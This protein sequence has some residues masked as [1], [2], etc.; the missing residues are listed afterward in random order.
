MASS[1]L[2][3]IPPE[4]LATI[5]AALA[6][7]RPLRPPRDLCALRATC[8]HLRDALSCHYNPAVWSA[9]FD[10]R[11][12]SAAVRRRNFSPNGRDYYDQLRQYAE[13]LDALRSGTVL[14]PDIGDIL[15]IVYVMLLD[16]DGKNRAQLEAAGVDAFLD[17]SIRTHLWSEAHLHEGWPQDDSTNSFALWI[18]WM[19]TTTEQLQRETAAV[20]EEMVALVMPF[21][22]NAYRYA[23]AEAPPHHFHLPLA[24]PA[25][26][27]PHSFPSAHGPYPVYAPDRQVSYPYFGSLPSFS[28]PPISVAAKLLYFARRE[29]IPFGIPPHIPATRAVAPPSNHPSPTQ[30]DLHEVNAHKGAEPPIRITW[31]W[32]SGTRL[33]NGLP[34]SQL[35]SDRS[36][37]WDSDYWR[38]RLCGSA[39]KRQ[40][41][42][43]PAKLYVPGS[44]DGLWQG[45]LIVSLLSPLFLFIFL[46]R[47]SSSRHKKPCRH[48]FE[49]LS[50]PRK[51]STK[52][53]FESR[54]NPYS[55]ALLN[56]IPYSPTI[57]CHSLPS[58]L[59]S[60]KKTTIRVGGRISL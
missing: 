13:V 56:T 27:L 12:D 33:A 20:R 4:I 40:P 41:K 29:I 10:S 26:D 9:A 2:H 16:N 44:M 11:F 28:P 52:C 46:H 8:R 14:R 34:D 37:R 1:P 6:S 60:R 36:S 25:S 50:I 38:R 18:K 47:C 51:L 43:R 17:A 35:S 5:A 24:D 3:R 49:K 58:L 23:Q 55:C 42:W 7:A 30:E 21:V 32:E 59:C 19:L 45:R 22:L 48:Y 15:R 54:I 53:H 31:D 57:P 39:W